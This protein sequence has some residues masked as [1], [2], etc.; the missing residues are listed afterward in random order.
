MVTLEQAAE[1]LRAAQDVL[2]LSHQYPD[3]DTLGSAFALVRTLQRMGKRARFACSH[4]IGKPYRFLE[5]TV[6]KQS[7]EPKCVVTVDVAAPSLLGEPVRSRWGNRVDLCLDHHGSGKEFA[8]MTVVEPGAAAAAEVIYELLPLLGVE[9]D[10]ETEA[11]LYAGIATDTGGFR[12]PNTTPR[13]MRIAASLME[14]GI[15][16]AELNRL[17]LDTKSRAFLELERLSLGLMRFFFGGRCALIVVTREMLRASGAREDETDA[18]PPLARR[19][20]GVLAG[21]TLREKENGDF[22]VS[23]RTVPG[24]NAAKICE[25]LGGGGHRGAA[26]C[27]VRRP[28]GADP[29]GEAAALVVRAVGEY[30]RKKGIDTKEESE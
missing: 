26:G 3:G 18:L 7:F 27:T 1:Y 10:R 25:T 29:A 2:V 15:D 14:A 8:R 30:L 23:V 11:C 6:E 13:T 28:Q 19:V 22:R 17:L 20:E 4:A 21:V 12:F 5:E 9:P 16:A 24:V